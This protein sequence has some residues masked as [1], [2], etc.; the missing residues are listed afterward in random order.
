[1]GLAKTT[2]AS[3]LDLSAKDE[4]QAAMT[5]K[6]L[7]QIKKR[8]G[9]AYKAGRYAESAA[10]ATEGA[11]LAK[12][13]GDTTWR[14]R[15]RTWE[16]ESHWQNK[17]ISAAIAA[18]TEAAE[19]TPGADPADSFNAISTLL[20]IAV[21]ERPAAEARALLAR[22]HAHLERTGRTASR[23]MLDISEG[24]LAARRGDWTEALVQYRAAYDHQLSDRGMPRFTEASYISKLAEASFML[25]DAAGLEQWRAAIN[26]VKLE[27][28]GDH[29]RAEQIRMLCHRAGLTEPEGAKTDASGA[30]RRLLRWLEEFQGHRS[31]YARDALLVLLLQGDW[32]SVETWIDYPGIG[33]DPFIAGDLH[34]ARARE[35]LGLPP[36]DPVGRAQ[37]VERRRHREQ[38]GVR[39][40][41][42][43]ARL[44]CNADQPRRW[45]GAVPVRH[46]PDDGSAQGPRG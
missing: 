15:L 17:D 7:E 11:A 33:D 24:N 21:A 5:D 36:R 44:R 6:E 4:D 25:G 46:A 30:A 18:L 42:R 23:H 39:R 26:A 27:V 12:R 34:L 37:R 45:P 13:L 8:F 35:D 41:E 2:L 1:M 16:G 29:L 19:E 38:V 40:D 14:V 43:H 3:R 20:S 10:L 31:E 22:G 9:L 28:E 32:L